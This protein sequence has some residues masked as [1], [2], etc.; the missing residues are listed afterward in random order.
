MRRLLA[1]QSGT[2]LRTKRRVLRPGGR[3]VDP[4]DLSCRLDR[5]DDQWLVSVRHHHRAIGARVGQRVAPTAAERLDL[6]MAVQLVTAEV[7]Q[8]EDL[9]AT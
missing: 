9:R 7:Q 5:P 8:Y 2:A 4:D 1:G 6:V 3:R